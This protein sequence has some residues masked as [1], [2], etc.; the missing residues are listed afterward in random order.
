M[1]KRKKVHYLHLNTDYE[2]KITETDKEILVENK[3]DLRRQALREE[4]IAF[5]VEKLILLGLSFTAGLSTMYLI[6]NP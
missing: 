4:Q 3:E 1:F 2:L 5:V 6:L